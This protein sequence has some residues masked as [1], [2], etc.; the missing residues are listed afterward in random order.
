MTPE[1]K[2]KLKVDTRLGKPRG[3]TVH[4][5]VTEHGV[6]TFT[7]R[8]DYPVFDKNGEHVNMDGINMF[9]VGLDKL[10]ELVK[11]G[12]EEHLI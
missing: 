8:L 9:E 5:I 4:F 12:L 10:E 1:E 3:V 6:G 2:D 7:A 11:F